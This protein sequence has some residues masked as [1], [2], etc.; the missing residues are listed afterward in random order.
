[1]VGVRVQETALSKVQTAIPEGHAPA[2][3]LKHYRSLC[4][5]GGG[6]VRNGLI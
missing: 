2:N 5:G 6:S 1:M 4:K 3:T